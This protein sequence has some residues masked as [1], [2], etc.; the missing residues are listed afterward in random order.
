MRPKVR[1][2]LDSALREKSSPLFL[3][4]NKS[5]IKKFF[6]KRG[7]DVEEREINEY[8]QEERSNG[9]VI[10]NDSER[11]KKEISRAMI[12]APNFFS[13]TYSDVLHL[14][15]SRNYGK[16]SSKFVVLIVDSLSLFVYLAALKSTKADDLI[17]AFKTI[18]SRSPYLPENCDRMSCDEGVEYLAKKSRNFFIS[19]GI[20][21]NPIPPRRLDRRSYG[22]NFAEVMNRSLRSYIEKIQLNDEMKKLSWNEK[23]LAVENRMNKKAR[24]V[25]KGYSS[26]DMLTQSPKYVQMLKF[27]RRLVSRKSLRENM[28]N[29]KNILLF[30]IVKIQKY[31]AK[32][33]LG[34]KESYS[35]FSSQF[36]IV[37]DRHEHDHVFYFTLGSV[38]SL[39]AVTESKF[40]F[41]EL[42][43]FSEISLGKARY[44]N[45]IAEPLNKR[46]IGD[47]SYFNV[48]YCDKVF[49]AS[50]NAF[51]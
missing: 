36:Y 33:G 9:V 41:H 30:S 27:D 51:D 17:S 20:R 45:C 37:L 11:K 47:Y 15:K 5:E 19:H 34:F 26:A 14:S 7:F 21:L 32:E 22:A 43:V 44:L 8:L 38:F 48:K 40:S 50:K 18:F 35:S 42:K 13:W 6:E 24:A 25:F 4:K 46:I 28:E 31:K 39:K 23:L 16:D 2:L 49:Y 29:P 3:S 12:L 10:R 1:K